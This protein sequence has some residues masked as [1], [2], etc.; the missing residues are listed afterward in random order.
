MNWHDSAYFLEESFLE[1]FV[2]LI[3]DSL[4]VS[5]M[6]VNSGRDTFS[7]GF[8]TK[9]L[10]REF[11]LKVNLNVSSLEVVGLYL[12]LASHGTA[13]GVDDPGGLPLSTPEGSEL[14]VNA[15]N[16]NLE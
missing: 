3:K 16:L 1:S 2:H 10:R 9:V 12:D 11:F 8:S 13:S 6:L 7:S 14:V 4:V 5:L 15:P